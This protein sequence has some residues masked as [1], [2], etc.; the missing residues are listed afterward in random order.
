MARFCSLPFMP[1]DVDDIAVPPHAIAPRVNVL[2][3]LL[4]PMNDLLNLAP[5]R[6]SFKACGYACLLLALAACRRSSALL[7]A[8]SFVS[9]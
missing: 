4:S 8:P 2:A 6:F 3:N 5:T 7:A 9:P 1:V